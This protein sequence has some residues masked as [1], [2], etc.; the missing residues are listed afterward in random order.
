M[1][2]AMEKTLYRQIYPALSCHIPEKQIA[3]LPGTETTLK[4]LCFTEC[5]TDKFNELAYTAAMFLDVSKA[6]GT[7]W[8][9]GLIYKIYT[10]GIPDSSL[11]RASVTAPLPGASN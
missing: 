4:L 9:T 5:V 2:K 10:A 1:G 3:F 6:C 7:V 8:T 11:L